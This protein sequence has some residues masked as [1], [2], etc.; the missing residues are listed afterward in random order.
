MGSNMKD[1]G[2]GCN[3]VKQGIELMTAILAV[4]NRA[5]SLSDSKEKQ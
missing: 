4:Y 1:K 3:V 5:S 2:T